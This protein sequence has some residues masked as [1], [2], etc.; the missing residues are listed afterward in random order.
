MSSKLNTKP[1]VATSPRA[2]GSTVS[3]NARN[4]VARGGVN[5]AELTASRRVEAQ[6]VQAA[7]RATAEGYQEKAVIHHTP[8]DRLRDIVM[9]PTEALLDEPEHEYTLTS[10]SSGLSTVMQDLQMLG[11]EIRSLEAQ[12]RP[13][14]PDHLYDDLREGEEARVGHSTPNS[15]DTPTLRAVCQIADK[16]LELRRA[17][18]VIRTHVVPG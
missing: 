12:L 2:S 11:H 6:S 8:L 17:L 7:Q 4:G 5:V 18:N 10:L 9:A 13:V 1:K 15:F 14:M 16:V 3:G